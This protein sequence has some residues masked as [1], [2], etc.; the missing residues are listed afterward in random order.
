MWQSTC[1][2]FSHAG[3]QT[4]TIT[5][6]LDVY[7]RSFQKAASLQDA[8]VGSFRGLLG[9]AEA[10]AEPSSVGL[11][12]RGRHAAAQYLRG[13]GMPESTSHY[14]TGSQSEAAPESSNSTCE[15][16]SSTGRTLPVPP[17]SLNQT[18]PLKQ[19]PSTGDDLAHRGHLAMLET[20]FWLPLLGVGCCWHLV[21][22][23]QGM[24]VTTTRASHKELLQCQQCQS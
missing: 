19:W 18:Y 20:C 23:S 15:E 4:D 8:A 7:F 2:P 1:L 13:G 17:D 9:M 3:T 10:Q 14:R 5:P 11:E 16:Q 24:S 22:R 12:D 21:G 6:G